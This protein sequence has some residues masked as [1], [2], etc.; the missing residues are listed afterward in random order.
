MKAIRISEFG[1]PEVLKLQEVPDPKP[2]S[3][4]VLVRVRA[5]GIN[6]VDT[7][8]RSG[9]YPR[10]PNLPFTPGNDAAG[11]VEA[12]GP[13]VKRFKTGDRVYTSGTITG[14]CAE[15]TLCE[16]SRVHPLPSKISFAQGAALGVPYGTA[17]RALFQRAHVKPGE[18][19]LV[20]GASGGVGLACVQFA[21]ASGM[22]VI[23]TAGTEKG[24]ALVTN[25]GAHHVA[26]HRTPD[27]EKQITGF[28]G[29]RGLD[30][31]AEM[32]ANVNLAKDLSLLA[33]AGGRVVVIGNRGTIEINPRDT[34]MREASILGM[35]LWAVTADDV[36]EIHAAIVAGLEAGTLR[37]VIGHELPLTEAPRAHQLV[38]EPG[39]YGKIVLVP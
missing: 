2:D 25:Q 31:I 8:V 10:K 39:A 18:T 14:S 23:G 37:P 38:L 32:L 36:V 5:A 7:Y 20:H 28:T 22:M 35:T 9:V 19:L 21:R 30:V 3:E 26:D 16:A 24:L 17:Y 33:P 27:Y 12:V 34:M 11:V 4:Q 29:G 6:P 1:G 15:L 13:G